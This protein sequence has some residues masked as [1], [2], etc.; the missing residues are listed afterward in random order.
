MKRAL[1]RSFYILKDSRFFAKTLGTM[2]FWQCFGHV[3]SRKIVF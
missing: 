2:C 3:Y 1:H